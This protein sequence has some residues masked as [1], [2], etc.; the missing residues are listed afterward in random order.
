MTRRFRLDPVLDLRRR[1]VE[2][3]EQELAALERQRAERQSSIDRIREA[4]RDA[5]A[6]LRARQGDGRLDLRAIA[7]LHAY[8]ARLESQL[9]GESMALAELDA[10]CATKRAELIV[11]HQELK[12]IEK[13]KER[14]QTRAAEAARALEN[15]L[16]DEV[17]TVRF[18]V[19]YRGSLTGGTDR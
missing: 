15:R 1:R 4:M 14:E 3:F 5:V 16:T 7:Q 9:A 6:T 19:R 8:Y 10:R 13:L 2:T 17:A 11:A 18:N 12:T